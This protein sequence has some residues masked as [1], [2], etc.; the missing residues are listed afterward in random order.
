MLSDDV[1]SKVTGVAFSMSA[2]SVEL[3]SHSIFGFR[4]KVKSYTAGIG[5]ECFLGLLI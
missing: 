4:S 5:S 2:M 1:R 3:Q